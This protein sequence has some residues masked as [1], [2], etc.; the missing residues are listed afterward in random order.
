[1][2]LTDF[3]DE[4]SIR[5]IADLLPYVS[6]IGQN[7]SAKETAKGGSVVDFAS[8]IMRENPSDVKAMLAILDGQKPSEYHC[9]AAT[10]IRD[11][12]TMISDPALLDLFGLPTRTLTKKSSGSASANTEAPET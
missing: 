9:N 3:K 1:M 4:N 2:K 10:V 7:S 6:K 8:V 11:V 12:V 5:V